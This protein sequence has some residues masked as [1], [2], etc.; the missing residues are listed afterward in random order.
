MVK[1]WGFSPAYQ[2]LEPLR[3]R[4]FIDQMTLDVKL[5]AESMIEWTHTPRL[6]LGTRNGKTLGVLACNTSSAYAELNA[7]VASS[8]FATILKLAKN[9][10]TS[11][12]VIGFASDAGIASFAERYAIEAASYHADISTPCSESA[13]DDESSIAELHDVDAHQNDASDASDM[14]PKDIWLR[15]TFWEYI[16]KAH[17]PSATFEQIAAFHAKS[18]SVTFLDMYIGLRRFLHTPS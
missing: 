4:D 16:S 17:E 15:R 3:G 2:P 11:T 18:S 8:P 13:H 9:C 5:P 1:H 14:L 10:R 7:Y 6:P 12:T